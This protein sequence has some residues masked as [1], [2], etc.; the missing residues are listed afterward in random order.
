MTI[1]QTTPIP[2]K[3]WQSMEGLLSLTLAKRLGGINRTAGSV[4]HQEWSERCCKTKSN[5]AKWLW[6]KDLQDDQTSCC[7]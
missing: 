3:V 1:V 7:S 6:C 5:P 2:I 4:L